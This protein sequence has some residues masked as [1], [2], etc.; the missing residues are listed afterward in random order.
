MA[1]SSAIEHARTR[2]QRTVVESASDRTT[3]ADAV[4]TGIGVEVGKTTGGHLHL[5]K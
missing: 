4:A 2:H 5:L 1:F 3:K